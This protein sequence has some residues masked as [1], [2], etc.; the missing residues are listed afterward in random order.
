M[1][2]PLANNQLAFNLQKVFSLCFR[3]GA[4]RG[5]AE[6]VPRSFGAITNAVVGCRLL[7]GYLLIVFTPF[8][9]F[10]LSSFAGQLQRLKQLLRVAY[11]AVFLGC[12]L[13]LMEAVCCKLIKVTDC[14]SRTRN[15]ALRG[16]EN[17]EQ[18]AECK[19]QRG[20]R[21]KRTVPGRGLLKCPCALKSLSTRFRIGKKFVS[22]SQ[23]WL[24]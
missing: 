9:E 23:S 3:A 13:Y 6:I 16:R 19:G 1:A 8:N 2:N 22:Q 7:V 12:L 5:R 10:L 17:S 15:A 14:D 11:L 21:R 24:K 20:K 18:R 4:F